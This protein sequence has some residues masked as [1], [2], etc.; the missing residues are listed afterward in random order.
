MKTQKTQL[1]QTKWYHGTNLK[2]LKQIVKSKFI[3]VDYFDGKGFYL[4]KDFDDASNHGSIVLVFDNIDESN[5]ITDD[6]NDGYFHKGIL[7][8]KEISKLVI[9]NERAYLQEMLQLYIEQFEDE[10]ISN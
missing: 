2:A 9:C 8:Y 5:L 10:N 4:T 6:V 7:S 1:K 3:S